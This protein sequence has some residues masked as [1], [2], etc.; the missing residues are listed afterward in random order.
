MPCG[1]AHQR[2]RAGTRGEPHLHAARGIRRT[3][4]RLRP[5]RVVTVDE[6]RFGAVD[7]QRLGIGD[8]A[9]DRELEVPPFLDRALRHHAG[10]PGLRPDEQRDRVQRRVARDADRRLELGEAARRC[11]RRVGRQ[12][13]RAFLEVGD[14]RLVAR[15]PPGAQLLQGEHQLDGV[16]QPHDP[17]ELRGRQ[18]AS[19]PDDLASRNIDV[20][21]H[22]RDRLV[23]QG[24]RFGRDARDR[25]RERRESGRSRRTPPPR[26][27][28]AAARRRP[29]PRARARDRSARSRPPGRAREAAKRAAHGAAPSRPA[30]RTSP[31]G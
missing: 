3:E 17:R 5:W 27:R 6:H 28:P 11:L 9:A 16:E 30:R 20:D 4:E 7:R 10:T 31:S 19:E 22:P 14:M 13:R 25:D 21:E 24:H 1:V 15:R 23:G 18:P 29:R 26:A 8:E 2:L 12:E